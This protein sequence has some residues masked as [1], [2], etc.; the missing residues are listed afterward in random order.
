MEIGDKL[1]LHSNMNPYNNSV[2]D[3][4][5]EITVVE[6]KKVHYIYGEGFGYGYRAVDESGKAYVCNWERY[7]STSA[8][9]E[10]IWHLEYTGD[11]NS[12]VDISAFIN[13]NVVEWFDIT[14]HLG[15]LIPFKPKFMS[16]YSDILG[17]CDKHSELY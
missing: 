12:K 14:Q 13:T 8:T 5:V 2:P 4:F 11:R 3:S 16:K 15:Y 10:W 6:K 7:D 17:Y 9:P 1:V